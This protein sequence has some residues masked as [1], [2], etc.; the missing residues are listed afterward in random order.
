MV[1]GRRYWHGDTDWLAWAQA[2]A[3]VQWYDLDLGIGAEKDSMQSDRELVTGLG[4]GFA[5]P[6]SP[7]WRSELSGLIHKTQTRSSLETSASVSLVFLL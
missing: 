1:I 2:D 6:L 7:N 3:G 5:W 4:V